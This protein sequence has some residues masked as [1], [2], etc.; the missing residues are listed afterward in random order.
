MTSQNAL[1]IIEFMEKYN[2]H[3]KELFSFMTTKQEKVINDELTWLLDS[4]VN[5][6]RL[7][8]KGTDLEQ[9]RLKLFAELGC[10]DKKAK[11]LI[12]ECPEEL[13]GRFRLEM[14]T[15]EEYV[16]SIKKLNSDVLSIIERKL[17]VQEERMSGKATMLTADTYTGMG[18]KVRKT[19][20]SGGLIGEV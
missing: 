1:C 10:A 2:A 3:Y 5:E 16:H 13:K 8:M 14:T 6:Q 20:V 19:T 12:E 15:L 11:E 17:A 18:A 9:K 7:V 4:L